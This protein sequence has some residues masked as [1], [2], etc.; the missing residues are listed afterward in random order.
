ML[1]LVSLHA[2]ISAY[3]I[4]FQEPE[5]SRAVSLLV[6]EFQGAPDDAASRWS[7]W[8]PFFR[9]NAINGMRPFASTTA[10]WRAEA[11]RSGRSARKWI[12]MKQGDASLM[13]RI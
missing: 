4:S 5:T 9:M 10:R 3:T 8:K 7:H 11:A 1:V 12:C 6:A 13:D 2:L